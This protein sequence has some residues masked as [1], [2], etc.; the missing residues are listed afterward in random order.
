MPLQLDAWT[1]DAIVL[2]EYAI[3]EDGRLEFPICLE[4][5]SSTIITLVP[6]TNSSGILR[7]AVNSTADIIVRHPINNG[8]LARASKVG[9]YTVTLDDGSK[10]DITISDVPA[11]QNLTGWSLQVDS[12]EPA[13]GSG[14]INVT[15]TVHIRHDFNLSSL[16]PW[17]EIDELKDVSGNATYSTTFN[18]DTDSEG[19]GAYLEVHRFNDSIRLTVNE[20]QLPPIDQVATRFDI[21]Q[22]IRNGTNKVDIDLSTTL[23]NR[24]RALEPT[25]Y[26]Q[27]RQNYGLTAVTLHPFRQV[28]VD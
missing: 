16:K 1:G 26:Q 23:Y 10:K 15:D 22:W 21:T 6:V 7:H 14:R 27:K 19:L 2:A 4:P 13:D 11:I 20:Q 28:L 9:T 25:I 3:T 8:L 5:G 18:L 24:L 12:W 17:T